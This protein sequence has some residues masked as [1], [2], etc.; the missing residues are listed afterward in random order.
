M[1]AQTPTLAIAKCGTIALELALRGIPTVVTY[2]MSPLDTALAKWLFRINLPH[3]SLPNLIL[4]RLLFPEL[5]GPALTDENLFQAVSSLLSSLDACRHGCQEV[6]AALTPGVPIA[7]FFP[8]KD[9]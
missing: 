6:R 7:P 8:F 1:N 9:L 4:N 2:G 3:Y 5:I